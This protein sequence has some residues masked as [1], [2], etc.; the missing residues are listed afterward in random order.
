MIWIL[1]QLLAVNKFLVT[2]LDISAIVGSE[3]Y[4]TA[5]K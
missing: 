3:W 1:V 4:C 5:L 2:D